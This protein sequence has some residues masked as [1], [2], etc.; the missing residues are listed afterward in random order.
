MIQSQDI[1]VIVQG[2]INSHTKECLKSL[3]RWLPDSQIIL[4]TWANSDV[5]GL[6]YSDVVFS[7]DP[8]GVVIDDEALVINNVNR[9]ILS[10]KEGLK[11]AK[12]RYCLK[13]RTDITLLGNNFLSYFNFFDKYNKPLHFNNRL[14]I[15]SY[16]T[17]N[18]R[19]LPLPFHVSDWVFFGNTDD[20][21]LY[22]ELELQHEDEM[23]W[24]KNNKREN[25]LFYTNL[26]TRYTPEQYICYN[27]T[28][29]FLDVEFTSFYDTKRENIELTEK[30]IANDFVVLDYNKQFDINFNKYNPNRYFE[31]FTLMTHQDWKSL[32]QIYNENGKNK[33]SMFKVKNKW[34]LK[35]KFK[36][37]ILFFRKIILYCLQK[38][39]IKEWVKSILK[40]I[41]I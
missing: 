7:K 22:F 8:G 11:L 37:F 23:R 17:R 25:R 2:N 36:Y 3:K 28:R 27:F 10:T 16:Y 9:Q 40:K 34:I 30:I 18:P 21:K 31:K 33:I 14:L 29:K 13:T 20:V 15:S 38:L 5:T 6:E 24:F 32:Y 19:V 41:S 1:S 4:S 26:L 39:G 12:R 35:C